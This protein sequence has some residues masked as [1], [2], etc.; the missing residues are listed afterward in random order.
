M[1]PQ[2]YVKSGKHLPGPLKDFHDQKDLFKLMYRCYA[3]KGGT[4]A[5]EQNGASVPW[6]TGQCYVIDWFL[7]F[8]GKRGWTLQ[9]SRADVPFHDLDAEIAMMKREDAELF[10]EMLAE[11]KEAAAQAA[12]LPDSSGTGQSKASG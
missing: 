10:R 2:E 5:Y 9:R 6:T 1:T 4:G 12:P 8:M 3:D 11:R 7:W